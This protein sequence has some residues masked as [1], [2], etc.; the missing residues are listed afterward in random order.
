[1]AST[2][3]ILSSPV[4]SDGFKSKFLASPVVQVPAD[5]SSSSSS[6]RQQ[7]KMELT[8]GEIACKQQQLKPRF[9]LEL[10]GLNCF[11]TLVPR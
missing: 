5:A 8:S 2:D 3:A 7:V 11:E 4:A 10:D 6:Q 1:M 9:A